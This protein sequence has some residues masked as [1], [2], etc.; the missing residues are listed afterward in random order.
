MSRSAQRAGSWACAYCVYLPS[1][2]PPSVAAPGVCASPATKAAAAS[3]SAAAAA[4][5]VRG[6]MPFLLYCSVRCNHSSA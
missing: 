5:R 1:S 4:N 3:K 6:H 2:P